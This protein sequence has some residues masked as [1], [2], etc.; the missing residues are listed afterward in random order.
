MVSLLSKQV[1]R[2]DAGVSGGRAV[3]TLLDLFF[4]CCSSLVTFICS[5]IGWDVVKIVP[6]LGEITTYGSLKL[7]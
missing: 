3:G 5:D 1:Q 6:S 7:Q 2:E 4:S